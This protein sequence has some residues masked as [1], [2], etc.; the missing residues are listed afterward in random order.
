MLTPRGV[1]LCAGGRRRCGSSPGSSA[2]PG[3]EVVGLALAVAPFLA[4]ADRP[5]AARARR[6]RSA[7]ASRRS[8]SR[9]GPG[10]T[11]HA[12][13]RATRDTA[14]TPLLL[15]EDAP[16]GAAGPP[17]PPG[18]H[19]S[20][21]AGRSA[22]SPTR[23]CRRPAAGTGS[24]RSRSTPP[25]P[26]GWRAGGHAWTAA[27]SC[28]S[29][30]RSRTSSVPPDAGDGRRVR[31]GPRPAAAAQRRGLLHDARLPGGRRPAPD[32]LALRRAHGRADDPPG[33]GVATGERAGV[34]GQ[35]DDGARA[36]AHARVR[37]GG[38]G[39]GERGG[40]RSRTPGS[41]SGWRAPTTRP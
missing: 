23:S 30:P 24:A 17:G 15:L 6:R 7:G 36:G 8:A 3:L 1:T 33:R 25:T 35:P 20:P 12:R 32:P 40:A 21:A 22:W 26:S 4:G 28:S 5:P 19:R 37:A 14:T 2:R 34:R 10:V 11:V 39:R 9:R 41:R 29:P 27:R 38:L 13:R 18:R 16:P 31:R